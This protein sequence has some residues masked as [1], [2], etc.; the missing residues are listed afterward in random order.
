MKILARLS[1]LVLALS[2]WLPIASAELTFT[3]T[4][5]AD[6]ATL[7]PMGEGTFQEFIDATAELTLP[8]IDDE[9]IVFW[10]RSGQFG[11]RLGLYKSTATNGIQLIADTNTKIPG[12][13]QK[14]DWVG[15]AS[16]HQGNVAFW[17]TSFSNME[18]IY[19]WRNGTLETIADRNTLIPNGSGTFQTLGYP[20]LD[21][22]KV[23]FV[24]ADVNRLTG[25]Y[26]N[27]NASNQALID[28]NTP[29]P[30]NLGSFQFFSGVSLEN[31]SIGFGAGGTSLQSGIFILQD[32]TIDTIADTTTSVPEGQGTFSGFEG[33]V[34]CAML[35]SCVLSGPWPLFSQGKSAFAGV[36][37]SGQFGIYSDVN[38]LSLIANMNSTFPGAEGQSLFAISPSLDQ[39]TLAFMG[40][41]HQHWG[42]YLSQEGSITKVIDTNDLL[43]EKPIMTLQIGPYGLSGNHLVFVAY[44]KDGT[45][46]IYRT[47]FSSE[48]TLTSSQDSFI[49]SSSPNKNEGANPTLRVQK[50]G[51]KRSVIGFQLPQASG[52]S[53]TKATLTLTM[54]QPTKNMGSQGHLVNVHRLMESFLEGNGKRIGI[55]KSEKTNGT[56]QGVTWSCAT[57]SD[58]SNTNT[59]CSVQWI[60]GD[61]VTGPASDSTLH[62]TGMSGGI[63]WDVTIDVRDALNE[64]NGTISW[65]LKL[66]DENQGGKVIYHSKEGALVLGDPSKGP[67]L[68]L[69]F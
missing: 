31:D 24:G 54:A 14:F 63:S 56:G 1:I 9:T 46:G 60:G 22:G 28:L 17:G 44:F 47:D 65:L 8:V 4:K 35:D 53:L 69:E 66:A 29:P 59:D 3:F 36:G 25:I 11:S 52:T 45:S 12:N 10:G 58:I 32:E 27:E 51:Q 64:G 42:I 5:I 23:A 68:L 61:V 19:I 38:G 39:E 37:S 40:L 6:T 49:R 16:L 30:A 15:A 55:P 34:D 21:N 33:V 7:V 57:D 13:T 41:N 43:N 26:M 50:Q 2:T 48:T 20:S 62:T 67:T 18:G